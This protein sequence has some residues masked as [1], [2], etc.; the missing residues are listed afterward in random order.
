V[1][2][3]AYEYL[4][5]QKEACTSSIGRSLHVNAIH[6]RNF[7]GLFISYTYYCMSPISCES[8]ISFPDYSSFES[9][10]K[11]VSSPSSGL[12]TK[13]NIC[14]LCN[15]SECD[16]HISLLSVNLAVGLALEPRHLLASLE[17]PL[18][19]ELNDVGSPA[20][21]ISSMLCLL[22]QADSFMAA[23]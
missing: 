3:I 17:S 13:S 10:V 19:F 23:Q 11:A 6:L 20:A 21:G 4:V 16:T 22:V 9:T 2:P 12:D 7:W 1:R 15:R 18:L 8:L 5:A 14:L